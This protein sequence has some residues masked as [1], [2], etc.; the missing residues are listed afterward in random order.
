MAQKNR[1]PRKTKKAAKK[2]NKLD[3]GLA[4]LSIVLGIVLIILTIGI[5]VYF[6]N[7][8]KK[9]KDA[10]KSNEE[11]KQEEIPEPQIPD[12]RKLL[13]E[14]DEKIALLNLKHKSDEALEKRI[15]Q[16][17]R[18]I[19]GLILISSNYFYYSIY[20]NQQEVKLTTIIG[21]LVNLNTGILFIYTFAA[22]L[23]YG[24]IAKFKEKINEGILL[25]FKINHFGTMFDLHIQETVRETLVSEIE[26]EEALK[27]KKIKEQM[28]KN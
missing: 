11:P 20:H 25:L 23:L 12:K 6:I 13:E 24:S 28:I 19:I 10:K 16:A 17:A 14:V 27:N 26:K 2:I 18:L 8:T 22:Y 15:F 9:S 21:D 1:L 7:E 5:I 3:D 4:I